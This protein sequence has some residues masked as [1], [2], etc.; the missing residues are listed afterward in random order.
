[1]SENVAGRR[2]R[3]DLLL[4]AEIGRWIVDVVDAA[5]VAV[6]VTRDPVVA[7]A[8]RARGLAIA[9]DV[10][11]SSGARFAF[12]AH[13]PTFLSA[14]QLAAY[15]HA[16][17]LHPGLLPWGRGYGPVFWALW[18]GEPAGATLHTMSAGL[19]K[20]PV[21]AQRAVAVAADDTGDS[22]YRRVHEASQ[23]L[24]LEWWP[25]LVAGERPTGDPQPTGG[26]YH[27][28]A[29]LLRL[30]DKAD[31]ESMPGRDVIRLA[32]ALAMPGMPG[33]R[34][35]MRHRLSIVVDEEG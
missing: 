8:A 14:D 3:F 4:G 11:T 32:R 19:D 1:M 10:P 21:V 6:V 28:R 31:I 2:E 5:D 17:N 9:R 33:L 24:F 15:E 35:G 22:L 13:W 16:W 25:R 29:D 30:R 26:S 23:A 12:S 34:V 7:D 20:G 18:A 27:A